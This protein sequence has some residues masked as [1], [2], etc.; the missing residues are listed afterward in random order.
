[1]VRK[2]KY[3][4]KKCSFGG[5]SFDSMKERDHYIYLLS[6]QQA[7]RITELEL[8]PK[9]QLQELFKDNLGRTHRAISYIA[10]FQY[11]RDKQIVVV[12]VKGMK[13]EV[14]RIKKKLFL[15]KYGSLNILFEEV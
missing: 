13:T 4:N 15:Y 12:D 8:Q 5:Y 9:F 2:N 3:S 11:K 10:D 1:M 6:E 14:Y 7:G